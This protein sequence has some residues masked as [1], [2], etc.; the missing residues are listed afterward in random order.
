[1]HHHHIAALVVIF[2]FMGFVLWT[3]FGSKHNRLWTGGAWAAFVDGFVDGFP[4]GTP[5]GGGFAVADGQIHAD[6]GLRHLAIAAAHL[7]AIPFFTGLADVREYRKSNPF[8][9][10]FQY[11]ETENRIPPPTAGATS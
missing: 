11:D 10:F 7:L 4:I 5:A 6:L 8:P 9:N 2:L 3:L 1:M